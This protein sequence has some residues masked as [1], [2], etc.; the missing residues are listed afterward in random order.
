MV[1]SCSAMPIIRIR[2]HTSPHFV[3]PNWVRGFT[4]TLWSSAIVVCCHCCLVLFTTFIVWEWRFVW[5]IVG[6]CND[7][8]VQDNWY[9]GVTLDCL[10]HH[11]R[12]S[13]THACSCSLSWRCIA[14]GSWRRTVPI[15]N[16]SCCGSIPRRNWNRTS[17]AVLFCTWSGMSMRSLIVSCY[18]LAPFN[19]QTL[20]K[21]LGRGWRQLTSPSM[22][23]MH[24]YLKFWI[25][26]AYVDKDSY[27]KQPVTFSTTKK[28]YVYGTE[29][30]VQKSCL[31]YTCKHLIK[32]QLLV[33]CSLTCQL[34][35]QHENVS[36]FSSA[37]H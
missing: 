28:G 19:V 36:R 14:G 1:T 26:F 33:E 21:T 7:A 24:R 3:R 8:Y 30:Y 35:T 23:S 6:P 12:M 25:C 13:A 29:L 5:V 4:P 22:D 2:C 17:W 9:G 10:L 16:H 11:H 15:F 34:L 18:M 37:L 20:L 27:W 32:L 31:I